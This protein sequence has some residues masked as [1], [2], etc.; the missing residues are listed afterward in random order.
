MSPFDDDVQD[1]TLKDLLRALERERDTDARSRILDAIRNRSKK[2]SRRLDAWLLERLA[3]LEQATVVAKLKLEELT[4]IHESL[5]APPWHPALFLGWTRLQGGE[6]KPMAMVLHDGGRLAVSPGALDPRSLAPGDEVLLAEARNVVVG[7]SD[8]PL[9]LNGE[10]SSFER[11]C[12]DGRIVL[13]SRDEEI[14][15]SAGGR[16]RQE[17]LEKGDLV[18][19]DRAG[20]IALEKVPRDV[21]GGYFLEELPDVSFDEIGGLDQEIEAVQRSIRLH[22]HHPDVARR[23]GLERRGSILLVGPPGTGKTMMAKALAHWLGTLSPSGR[24][25]FMNVKPAALHSVWYGESERQYRR[26]FET[27]REMSSTEP[28]VPV[29]MFFDEVDAIGRRRGGLASSIDDRVLT[30]FMTELDGLET[31]GNILV[32][33]ATN[34]RAALDPALLRP[35]RLGDLVLDIPRPRREAARAIYA[36]HLRDGIPYA[37]S[38]EDV[39][40]TAISRLY[41]PNADTEL[42]HLTLRDGTRRTVR[43]PDLVSG[44][45][46]ANIAQKA[47]E[48][49]CLRELESDQADQA[50]QAEATGVSV[51]DIVAATD[52]ELASSSRFLTPQNCRDHLCDLPQDV[53]VVRVEPLARTVPAP[54]NFRRVA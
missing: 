34:R 10:T 52:E 15:V 47:I 43:A 27:A 29:V 50:D 25:R 14:V 32:V 33:A 30:A 8:R 12:E 24:A 20:W 39:I 40:A 48:R 53:D 26:I 13:R 35:G 38:R 1:E 36:T 3:N 11:R 49:A 31:R 22:F 4:A 17:T 21:D 41:A 37:T 2:S 6:A 5:T 51:G 54:S 44:A 42:A 19:W 46:I 45:L 23:Y 9:F 7:K 18:L 28:D 16:L